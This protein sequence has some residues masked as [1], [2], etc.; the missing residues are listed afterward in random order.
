MEILLVLFVLVALLALYY[1]I[2]KLF[3][4]VA[5]KKGHGDKKY[6]WICFWLSWI[7]YLLVIALPDRGGAEKMISDELPDL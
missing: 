1:F 7:G 4:E 3:Y 5:M 2:A 6:F